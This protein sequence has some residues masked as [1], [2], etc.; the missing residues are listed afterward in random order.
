MGKKALAEIVEGGVLFMVFQAIREVF[1]GTLGDREQVS[2]M[3]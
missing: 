1:M 2:S 3:A